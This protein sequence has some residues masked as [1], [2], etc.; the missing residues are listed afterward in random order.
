MAIARRILLLLALLSL[1]QHP[2]LAG[3][4]E[5]KKAKVFA[6]ETAW[7]IGSWEGTNTAFDPSL[8]VEITIL[9]TGEVY[10]YVH[11]QNKGYHVTQGEK[12]VK[13]NKLAD[14]AMRGKMLDAK[15][16]ILEDG[17]K[18][19]IDEIVEG[20][21]TT[22]AKL[23]IV[24]QYRT[25]GDPAELTAIQ[26][27]VTVQQE[28]EAHHKDHDFWHS[29]AFW[30]VVAAGTVA[31]ATNHDNHVDVANPKLTKDQTATLQKYYK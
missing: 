18:L 10:C 27:R 4:H 24:V 31:A 19:Q 1:V 12:V 6:D 8:P 5:Y 7:Y 26:Q 13:L 16:I 20:L 3:K 23:G 25:P 11:G 21:Q 28:K 30:G 22:V 14:I 2:A 29:K 15:T 9:A 17:G